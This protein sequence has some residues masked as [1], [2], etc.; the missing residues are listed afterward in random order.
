MKEIN[1][2]VLEKFKISEDIPYKDLSKT[3]NINIDDIS[4]KM[5]ILFK[6]IIDNNSQS[7]FKNGRCNSSSLKNLKAVLN[8][9]YNKL[10]DEDNKKL[11]GYEWGYIAH[12]E[13]AITELF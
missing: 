9:V 3:K 6:E 7:P 11:K 1:Q 12:F 4:E 2:Y 5:F 8:N 13:T 10:E